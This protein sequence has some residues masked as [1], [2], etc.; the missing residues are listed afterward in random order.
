MSDRLAERPEKGV[1]A[2]LALHQVHCYVINP[3]VL[4]HLIWLRFVIDTVQINRK[5]TPLIVG[6]GGVAVAVFFEFLDG[7]QGQGQRHGRHALV[8]KLR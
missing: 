4:N 3:F 6:F 1:H 5:Q 7:C 2:R 8:I